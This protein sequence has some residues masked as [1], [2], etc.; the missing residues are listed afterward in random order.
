MGTK[1][2][3]QTYANSAGGIKSM[4]MEQDGSLTQPQ[5]I[6]TPLVYGNSTASATLTLNSTS[7][8]TKG[9]IFFGANA[10][11]DENNTR[12]G[13]GLTNPSVAIDVVS[14]TIPQFMATNTSKVRM[15]AGSAENGFECWK[16]ATPT[17]AIQIGMGTQGSAITDDIVFSRYNGSAWAE[18]GRMNNATSSLSM[19][20]KIGKL[21]SDTTEGKYGVPLVVDTVMKTNQT[22]SIAATN[23]TSASTAGGMYE[24][25]YYL[26]CTTASGTATVTVDVVA[27]DGVART[28]TSASVSMASTSNMTSGT[29]MTGLSTGSVQWQTTVTGTISSAQYKVAVICKRV[30]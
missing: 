10:A 28:Q 27:T 25:T 22:A 9:K 1:L 24:V 5:S 21:M 8:A 16:D 30:F 26:I 29:F 4:T 17:K 14:S 3:F 23:F 19:A 7:H 11:Y 13:I 15:R 20:G 2:V 6:T 12:L 18:I